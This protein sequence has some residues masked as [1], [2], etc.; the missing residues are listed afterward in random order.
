MFTTFA[1]G[2]TYVSSSFENKLLLEPKVKLSLLILHPV[3]ARSWYLGGVTALSRKRSLLELI[4]P[5][6]CH[7]SYPVEVQNSPI[8]SRSLRVE[9]L[10]SH[11]VV[12]QMD[13]GHFRKNQKQQQQQQNKTKQNKNKQKKK[14]A[15]CLMSTESSLF[16]QLF[17]KNA[18]FFS[19]CV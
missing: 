11:K 6:N 2:R 12:T 3:A 10:T 9:N 13:R 5:K 18:H 17:L 15:I 19:S 1:V 14:T 4:F 16:Q 7:R 8:G